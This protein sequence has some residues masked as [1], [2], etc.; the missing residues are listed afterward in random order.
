MNNPQPPWEDLERLYRHAGERYVKK[1]ASKLRRARG[2]VRRV[3]KYC[4]T[5]RWLDCG[6]SAGFVMQAAREAGFEVH[7]MD[8]D[9]SGLAY[10]RDVLNLATAH[11]A[12]LEDFEHHGE[13]FD[14]VSIYDVIEHVPDP[15]SALQKIASLLSPGGVV[16]IWT[17]RPGALAGAT[18]CQYLASGKTGASLLLRRKFARPFAAT[19]WV[20]RAQSA[21]VAQARAT[22]SGP[23]RQVVISP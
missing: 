6:C 15:Y 18:R 9:R 7:G 20:Y 2:N 5:G 8:I 12:T 1:A 19:L 17:P 14:V 10:A 21:L 23:C 11:Y 3:Q 13:R 16:D 4:L 22:G